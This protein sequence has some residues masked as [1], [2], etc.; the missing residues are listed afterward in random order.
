MVKDIS[1]KLSR[2]SNAA[3]AIDSTVSSTNDKTI[4]AMSAVISP[5]KLSFLPNNTAQT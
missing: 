4:K 1:G 3:S 5:S 2:V